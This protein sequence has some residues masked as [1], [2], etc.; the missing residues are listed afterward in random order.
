M[1][2]WAC[3]QEWSPRQLL[4]EVYR[5]LPLLRAQSSMNGFLQSLGGYSGQGPSKAPAK[6][7][8]CPTCHCGCSLASCIDKSSLLL[9][10]R[11]NKLKLYLN[12]STLF[13]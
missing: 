10:Q 6:S 8:Q 1:N 7:Q 9:D 4:E 12:N 2:L 13:T 5:I 3:P 11:L